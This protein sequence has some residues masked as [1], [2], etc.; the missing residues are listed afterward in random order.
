[1]KLVNY[2]DY[3]YKGLTKTLEGD[4]IGYALFK[5]GYV[6]EDLTEID[7]KCIWCLLNKEP[8]KDFAKLHYGTGEFFISKIHYSKFG[9]YLDDEQ[10]F[11]TLS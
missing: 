4:T 7:P 9:N 1:M 8:M 5:S 11:F 3:S 2:K 10:E 6:K